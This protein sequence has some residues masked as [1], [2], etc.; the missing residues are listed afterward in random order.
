[1][2][3]VIIVGVLLILKIGIIKVNKVNEG[4][5][6]KVFVKLMIIL[7]ILGKWVN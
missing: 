5:V 3:S 2:N 6:C 1:M 4:I 7:V